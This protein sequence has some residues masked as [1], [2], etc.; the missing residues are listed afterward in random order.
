[1]RAAGSG[2]E[3]IMCAEGVKCR[4]KAINEI[5]RYSLVV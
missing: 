3:H 2:G 4:E 1:M 5:E